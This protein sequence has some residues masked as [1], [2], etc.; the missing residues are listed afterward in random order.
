MG[1][2][3]VSIGSE[4][5]DDEEVLK[6]TARALTTELRRLKLPPLTPPPPHAFVPGSGTTFE[7]KLNRPMDSFSA[8]CRAQPDG[9]DRSDALLGWDLLLPITL[10]EPIELRVLAS[11]RHHDRPFRRHRPCRRSDA[12]PTTGTSPAD[13]GVLRQPQPHQLVRQPRGPASSRNAPGPWQDN[14]DAAFYT[15]M[16]LRAAEHSLRNACPS[17]TADHPETQSQDAASTTSPRPSRASCAGRV[18]IMS[19]EVV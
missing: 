10:P 15:A 11:R 7:E 3:L 19:R 1:I 13:A 5:W 17:T 16:Y 14:L 8:L 6:P 9:Q 4:D 2:Y 18:R 12:G